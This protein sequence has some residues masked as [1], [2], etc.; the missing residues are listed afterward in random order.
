VSILFPHIR[1]ARLVD[2]IEGRL[3]P[4]ELAECDAHLL[5][6][7]RCRAEFAWLERVIDLMRTDA[8]E[9]APPHVVA[10]AARLLRP[11]RRPA[12]AGIPQLLAALLFDSA[13]TLSA[14]GVRAAHPAERQMLFTASGLDLDLRVTQ[15]DAQWIVSG[16]VLGQDVAG[17]VELR[18]EG[19]AVQ[20]PLS[21]LS[22]FRL[23]PVAAG[24]YTLSLLLTDVEIV[25]E[26]LEIGA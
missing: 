1:F 20:A 19:A 16:Q 17:E 22:E 6:C 13:Q 25:V 15:A 21:E 9:D 4:D 8:Q 12:A 24:T 26:G 11:R 23:S 3:P 5:S 18:R 14:A 10:R 2:L 7:A